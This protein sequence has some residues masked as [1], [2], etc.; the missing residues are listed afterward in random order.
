MED[1][2]RL[3]FRGII[4][5]KI[6]EGMVEIMVAKVGI[7]TDDIN[8]DKKREEFLKSELIRFVNNFDTE[9]NDF[10]VLKPPIKEFK[11]EFIGCLPDY[12]NKDEEDFQDDRK[13]WDILNKVDDGKFDAVIIDETGVSSMLF[14]DLIRSS[15]VDTFIYS[16]TLGMEW[17]GDY[18]SD[19]GRN[20]DRWG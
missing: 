19:D 2:T 13:V 8:Y 15:S 10:F 9:L 1:L 18:E 3:N 14:L 16:L 4:G 12:R 6:K 20:W 7:I 5:L 11:F 17:L